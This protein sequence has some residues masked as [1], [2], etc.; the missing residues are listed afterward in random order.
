S[1]ALSTYLKLKGEGKDKTF[2]RGA[3]R[4]IKYVIEL[5]GDLPIDDYSS[6][7]ASKFRDYLLDR[8]LLISSVKR[9]FSSIRSIINLSITE[10]GISCINAFSKTYMPDNDNVEFR[11]PIPIKD[12]RHIQSLC[13][14]YDDDLRWLIALLSDTGMRLGEGVALLKSDINLNCEIP[15]IKLVPHPWRRLKTKGSQRYI[16][17]VGASLWACERILKQNNDSIYA[18]PRYTSVSICNA[19]SASAALN[20]WMKEK[21][22]DSYVIHGFRH[23]FRDRLRAIECPSDIIDQLGGWRLKS[24]G[25]GYGDG[26]KIQILFKWI[27]KIIF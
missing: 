19:N 7:D 23:S 9:V 20:K 22:S 8:G 14:E 13:R 25:Q 3:N 16:P 18:F 2:I 5:L 24:V 4:N 26:F 15:H 1:E 12:I 27:I 11:K 21:L 10:E 6:K 17:L